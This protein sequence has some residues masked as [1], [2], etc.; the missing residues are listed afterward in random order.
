V[1]DA[2]HAALAIEFGCNWI[3]LDRGSADSRTCVGGIRWIEISP[4]HAPSAGFK[5]I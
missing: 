1:P 5:K 3:S 2:F 4:I